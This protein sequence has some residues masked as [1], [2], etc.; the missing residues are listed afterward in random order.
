MWSFQQLYIKTAIAQH[1]EITTSGKLVLVSTCNIQNHEENK[2][3]NA[4]T[5]ISRGKIIQVCI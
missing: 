1:R 2:S 3:S 5:V 4:E